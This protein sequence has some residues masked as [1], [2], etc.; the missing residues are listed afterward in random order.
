MDK[1][2]DSQRRINIAIEEYLL[3][4]GLNSTLET[5][6]VISSQKEAKNVKQA[7]PSANLIKYLQSGNENEFFQL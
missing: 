3:T 6:K 4:N 2:I 1:R 5:F 7:R